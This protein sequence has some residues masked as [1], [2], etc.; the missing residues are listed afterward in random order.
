MPNKYVVRP[1]P[2]IPPPIGVICE[3]LWKILQNWQYDISLEDGPPSME[4]ALESCDI[5]FL[6][7]VMYATQVPGVL[8]SAQYLIGRIK[9]LRQVQL[10]QVYEQEES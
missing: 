3:D 6:Q 7:G 1:M 2:V 10:A 9:N 5:P 4:F 8:E